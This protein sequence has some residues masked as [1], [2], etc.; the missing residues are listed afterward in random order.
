M[1]AAIY[2]TVQALP[3]TFPCLFSYNFELRYSLPLDM[4]SLCGVC[5]FLT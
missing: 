2:L 5:N 1:L 3:R 4:F